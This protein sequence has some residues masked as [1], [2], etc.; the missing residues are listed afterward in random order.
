MIE[1]VEHPANETIRR[2]N[3]QRLAN[4]QDADNLIR[5]QEMIMY[6]GVQIGWLN[7]H[8]KKSPGVALMVRVDDETRE[9]IDREV[10]R[11]LGESVPIGQPPPDDE[12][13]EEEKPKSQI[14]T[15]D[16]DK[17]DES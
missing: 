15:P 12:E 5:D 13:P 3:K 8:P 16:G 17:E 7:N 2:R 1:I 14:W 9:E 10:E 11:H 4:G 6:D